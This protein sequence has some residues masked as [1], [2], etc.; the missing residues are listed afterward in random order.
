MIDGGGWRVMNSSWYTFEYRE[1]RRET[2]RGRGGGGAR[3]RFAKIGQAYGNVGLSMG[4]PG[5]NYSLTGAMSS[6]SKVT[7]G[8]T[9]G[10]R[11]KGGVSCL[12]FVA[13]PLRF[14][15]SF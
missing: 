8:L 3:K 11:G 7:H 12:A 14:V 1:V 13:L 6:L 10:G 15:V 9:G 5:M 2:E 4:Y